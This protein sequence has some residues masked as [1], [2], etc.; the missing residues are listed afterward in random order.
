MIGSTS[1]T[2]LEPRVKEVHAHSRGH[3]S[4]CMVAGQDTLGKGDFIL[5]RILRWFKRESRLISSHFRRICLRDTSSKC[6]AN[7]ILEDCLSPG[8]YSF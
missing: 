8:I 7:W 5:H 1:F 3:S 4:K 2:S 6:G